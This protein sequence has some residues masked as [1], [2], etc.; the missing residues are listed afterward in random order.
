MEC[1]E[2]E[3]TVL[4]FCGETVVKRLWPYKTMR[5]QGK[6]SAETAVKRLFRSTQRYANLFYDIA[7][8]LSMSNKSRHSVHHF[9]K[10]DILGKVLGLATQASY[11]H[12]ARVF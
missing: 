5:H 2:G 3:G 8:N 12:G 6:R 7:R 1:G 4:V 10:L 11:A 9:G